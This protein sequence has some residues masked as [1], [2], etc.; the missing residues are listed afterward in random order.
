MYDIKWIRE[1]PDVFDRSLPLAAT[2]PAS[3]EG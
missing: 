2:L 3:G 1:H